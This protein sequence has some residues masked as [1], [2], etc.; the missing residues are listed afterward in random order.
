MNR[1]L[2]FQSALAA[3][4][5]AA[6][7]HSA[8]GARSNSG[9]RRARQADE[10][11]LFSPLKIRGVTLRNRIAM[12]PMCQYSSE[13][14]FANDWHLA[15][16]AA[17]AVGGAG[18]L[19]AEATGIV[20]EG[21]IT[22]NC[23]GI[24]KDEHV[25]ALQRVTEF[26]I[27]HGA[28]PGIQLAHAGVKGSRHRPI[29][30]QRGK[31]VPVEDG[32]WEPVGPT[33]KRYRSDGMAPRALTVPEIR[34]IITSFAEAAERSIAAGF[35]VIEL[36]FAHGY[37]GHSF[38]SP[39]MNERKDDYGGPF[40]NRVRF[41]METVKA[42][43]AVLPEETPLLVRFSCTDWAPGG[44]TLEDSLKAARMVKAEGVD[45]IDCSTGGATRNADIPVGPDY[46]LPFATALRKDAGIA[47][48]AVGL[49]TEPAQANA[50]IADGQA[51]LV[52]MGRELLRD[53]HWPHRAWVELE[54]DTPPPIAPEYAWALRETRR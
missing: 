46:Q 1:R 10:L 15:H 54:S 20:P 19:I 41:L 34:G 29:H 30:P 43:R 50:I 17:R 24:W 23:L 51:D 28:V 38:M 40:E 33:A 47:T 22:P 37:L 44:W 16:H 35:Q 25:P 5:A 48:G 3:G 4:I 9:L 12:S 42:V 7:G 36:H 53:P 8:A 26:V 6:T 13:D 21:R 52:L 11:S 49:I 45:L 39:L 2:F 18:L 14:G 32:G 27:A 31:F